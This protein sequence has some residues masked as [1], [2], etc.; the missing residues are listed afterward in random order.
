MAAK[1]R[2]LTLLC[3][4]LPAMPLAALSLPLYIIVP[5]YYAEVLG[6]P[7]AVVGAALLAARIVDAVVDPLSGWLSD[8][9]RPAFGRRRAT[10]AA[11]IPVAALG[12]V[13]VFWPLA[14]VSGWYLGIWA[15][16]MSVGFTLVLLSY[17]AWGAELTGDY[18]ERSRLTGYREA[19][20]LIGTLIAIA[21][22]FAIGIGSPGFNGLAVL[23]VVVAALLVAAGAATLRFVPEPEDYSTG[24]VRLTDGLRAMA[25]NRPFVRLI[26]AYLVNGLGNGIPATLFLYFVSQRLEAPDMRGPLLFLYFLAGIAGVPLSVKL[27]AVLGKHR[28]WCWAMLANCAIFALVP[29]LGAGDVLAFAAICVAT[30]ICLGFDLSLP[31]AIQADVIDVDTAASGEQRSGFYFAIWSLATKLSLALAV[32]IVFPLLAWVGF[33]ASVS[34]RNSDAALAGLVATYVWLPIGFKVLAVALMWSFPIDRDV[35][36]TLRR[37]IEGRRVSL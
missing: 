20:T 11:G 8:R 26:V 4:A 28:A 17:S 24:D 29:L 15:S 18:A 36:A 14:G 3:Y 7:L 25:A 32:G 13:M 9:W 27:A 37:E 19:A 35:Q 12:A 33:D 34:A 5:T 2:P 10:F 21:L 6:L 23:G 22:P 30:G 31:A 16:L 1:L